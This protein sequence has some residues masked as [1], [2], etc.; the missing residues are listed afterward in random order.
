MAGWRLG[1][2]PGRRRT[3]DPGAEEDESPS[4]EKLQCTDLETKESLREHLMQHF[5]L[6][7]KKMRFKGVKSFAQDYTAS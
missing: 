1:S 7:M 2:P 3:G 5:C 4:Y 6:Q